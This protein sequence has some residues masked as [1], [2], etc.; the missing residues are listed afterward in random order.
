MIFQHKNTRRDNV[1]ASDNQVQGPSKELGGLSSCQ[2]A[3]THPLTAP[4][5]QHTNENMYSWNITKQVTMRRN[6]LCYRVFHCFLIP[7]FVLLG[8]AKS[9]RL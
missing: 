4:S 9:R 8:A 5:S 3:H 6:V 2:A 1:L 7:S